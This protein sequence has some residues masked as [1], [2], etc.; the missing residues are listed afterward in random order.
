LWQEESVSAKSAHSAR[1]RLSFRQAYTFNNFHFRGDPILG[2]NE[3]PG[4]PRQFYQ[5]EFLYE[6]P[7]GA[8]LGV[9]TQISSRYF[10][11]YDDSF[12]A[13][14][15]TIYN[16]RVGYAPSKARWEVYVDFKN[17]GDKN[18]AIAVTPAYTTRAVQGVGAGRDTAVFQSGD[19]FSFFA[20]ISVK[21]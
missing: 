7:S 3:L 2:N 16:A 13:T 15:Y 9:S 12:S 5:G 8:Y 10:V 19:G 11:D 20:G 4:L 18:Y 6:H 14:S 17:L 1:H 21:L